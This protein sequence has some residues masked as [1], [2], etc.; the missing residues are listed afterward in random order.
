MLSTQINFDMDTHYD[1]VKYACTDILKTA[2]KNRR[3]HLKK[4]PFDNVPV[5]LLSVNL[6]IRM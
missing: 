6:L 2:L 5:N 4:K 1:A 3:H